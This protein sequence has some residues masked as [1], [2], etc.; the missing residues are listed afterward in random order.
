MKLKEVQQIFTGNIDYLTKD[1]VIIDY[2]EREGLWYAHSD[3][4]DGKYTDAELDELTVD[5]IEAG[6]WKL[7]IYLDC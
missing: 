3:E 2:H 5:H 7:K 4:E 6:K 1:G